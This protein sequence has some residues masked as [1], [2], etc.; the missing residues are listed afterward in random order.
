VKSRPLGSVTTRV[1]SLRN[2]ADQPGRCRRR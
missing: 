2:T 1:A